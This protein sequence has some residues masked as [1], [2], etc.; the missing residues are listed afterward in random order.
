MAVDPLHDG[1]VGQELS[2]EVVLEADLHLD[3]ALQS[4]RL[5]FVQ[6][7]QRR[8]HLLGDDL[9]ALFRGD[10]QGGVKAVVPLED[11]PFDIPPDGSALP[12]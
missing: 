7:G 5:E 12:R 3:G 6:T 1:E 10:G 4:V 11:R 2:R 8:R 9:L